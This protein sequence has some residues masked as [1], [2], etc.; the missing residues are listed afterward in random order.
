MR[1]STSEYSARHTLALVGATCIVLAACGGGSSDTKKP[2]TTPVAEAPVTI[3]ATTDGPTVSEP[4]TEPVTEAPS[5]ATSGGDVKAWT[6]LVYSI[7]DTDLEPFMMDDVSEMGSVGSNDDLSI[8]ALV[9]RAA[10]YSSDPVLEIP[11]WQGAKLLNIRRGTA[12]I[13]EEMGDINTGDPQVLADF[14][15][16]GI[17]ENP[18]EHYSLIISD[19]GASWP[20]VGGDESSDNDS[21]SLEE[22]NGAISTG[23]SRTGVEQLD[24]LGF[25]ACLMATYEVATALAPLA[26]RMIASQELEPGHGWDYNS[27]GVL[28][29]G[30]PVD[31]DTLGS[32]IL[33][34]YRTQAKTEG[35]GTDITLSLLDLTQMPTLDAAMAD[36]SGALAERAAEVAPIVGQ[37]LGKTLGFGRSPDPTQDTH[38]ADLG[39][40]VSQIG[41]EALDVSDQADAVIRAIGGV[42]KRTVEGAA[43]LKSTGLSIY[44]PPNDSLFSANYPTVVGDTPWLSMLQSYYGA[45]DAIPTEQQ[46]RFTNVDGTADISFGDDGLTITGQ[47]DP[48]TVANIATSTVSYGVVSD[49][50]SI[51]FLGEEPGFVADD[52]TFTASGVYDLTEFTISDGTDSVTAYFEL[53]YGDD[54]GLA[55]IDIPMAYYSPDDV[56]GETYQDVMLSITLDAETFDIIEETYYVYNQELGTYGELTADPQGIIVPEIFSVSADGVGTWEATSDVG[57]FAE[58]A[59]LQYEVSPLESGT[60]LYIDL[61]VTDFGGNSALVSAVTD[62]P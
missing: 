59:S 29:T 58:L 34:G 54:D 9:D 46:P 45:G 24:L 35:T 40:L 11:N 47:L 53:T 41:V 2:G 23:L 26:Q 15:S 42:V 60:V 10:D 50:G 17:T 18:A 49:D 21:L 12:D 22:I 57:L 31:V 4:V 61:S 37:T 52:G 8:V 36:F 28:L 3:A 1:L 6:V 14:I 27:L 20:G 44:F 38:M 5:A 19:H 56:G 43:T 25:D 16:R 13:V 39:D 51:A 7:A 30:E 55:T 62:V 48:A 33:D 32:A